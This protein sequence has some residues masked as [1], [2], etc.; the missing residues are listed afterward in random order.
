MLRLNAVTHESRN[1]NRTQAIASDGTDG[2]SPGRVVVFGADWCSHTRHVIE[3]L[4]ELSID[5]DYIDVDVD[6]EASAWVKRVNGGPERKPTIVI[7]D[8]IIAEPT[9]AQL[10]DMLAR[11]G[12]TAE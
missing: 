3:H 2:K 5:Y 6:P 8:E 12:I 9:D 10:D 7:N 4:D 1:A 11:A